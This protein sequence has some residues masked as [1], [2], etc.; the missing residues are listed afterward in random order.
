VQSAGIALEGTRIPKSSNLPIL[1]LPG[2][3]PAILTPAAGRAASVT[4]IQPLMEDVYDRAPAAYLTRS[5]EL[6]FLANALLTGCSVYS[7]PFTVEEAWTAAVGICNLGLEGRPPN[8][9]LVHHD[10]LT[11]FQEGWRL[12]HE[13][14]GMFVSGQLVATLTDL[15]SIDPAT[16]RDLQRLRRELERHRK[17]SEPWRAREALDVIAILDMP[18]WASLEG[19]LNECPVLPATLKAIV[20]GQRDA[21]SPTAFE[22]FTTRAEIVKV[23]AFAGR[24]GA[25]LR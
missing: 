1:Q 9:T 19:L 7:R 17:R 2:E 21:V 14:V 15:E 13:E 16:Q 6:A 18:T 25:L 23:Q 3:G 5:R 4:P 22:C 24:L 20:D 12:L 8:T 11:A 10:L